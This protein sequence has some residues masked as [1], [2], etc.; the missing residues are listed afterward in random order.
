MTTSTTQPVTADTATTETVNVDSKKKKKQQFKGRTKGEAQ[1]KKK[2]TSPELWVLL[3]CPFVP[4][5]FPGIIE[6][7]NGEFLVTPILMAVFALCSSVAFLHTKYTPKFAIVRQAPGRQTSVRQTS[8]RQ[9]GAKQSREPLK[10]P[11]PDFLEEDVDDA[12]EDTG[13][14]NDN[15]SDFEFDF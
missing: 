13:E 11:T 3:A 7:P 5:L 8:A 6:I 14:K 2:T 9:S 15:D 10:E 12:V 1:V 4:L